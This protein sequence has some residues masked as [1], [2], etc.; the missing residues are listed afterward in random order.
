MSSLWIPCC[1]ASWSC[2]VF[3]DFFFFLGGGGGG[4]R[5]G[6]FFFGGEGGLFSFLFFFVFRC[7]H[8]YSADSKIEQWSCD[9]VSQIAM[10]QRSASVH[11]AHG[12]ERA[13]AGAPPACRPRVRYKLDRSKPRRLPS[14]VTLAHRRRNWHTSALKAGRLPARVPPAWRQRPLTMENVSALS[15]ESRD[16]NASNIGYRRHCVACWR[17]LDEWINIL[18]NLSTVILPQLSSKVVLK[19]YRLF[20]HLVLMVYYEYKEDLWG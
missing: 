6:V 18:F 12:N 15:R 16:S 11:P 9:V 3:L 1:R 8:T 2:W 13:S 5:G 17:L 14:R 10:I 7:G 19:Q 20:L 4:V